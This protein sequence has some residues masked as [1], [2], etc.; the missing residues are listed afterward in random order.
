[1]L[2]RSW[3]YADASNIF[4]NAEQTFRFVATDE[5]YSTFNGFNHDLKQQKGVQVEGGIKHQWSKAQS[6]ATGYWIDTHDEIFLDPTLGGGFGAN[7]SYDQT[8]RRGLELEQSFDIKGIFQVNALDAW[9]MGADYTFEDPKFGKGQFKGERIPLTPQHMFGVFTDFGFADHWHWR[10]DARYVG[11]R[12]R[13]NDEANALDP[14]KPYVLVDMRLTYRYQ[15]LEIFGGIDNLF[16][17]QYYAFGGKGTN[18]TNR[19]YYP[20]PQRSL[21]VGAKVKF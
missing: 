10:W 15:D 3:Q 2:F 13:L 7:S 4:I 6:K 9:D 11:D 5:V 21:T 8:I 12:Y 20:A 1:M 18:S 16:A 19:N 17:Q 14:L